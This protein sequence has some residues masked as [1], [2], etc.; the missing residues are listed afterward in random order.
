MGV[1]WTA[2]RTRT[3]DIGII[4][5]DIHDAS[6]RSAVLPESTSADR[7]STSTSTATAS[8]STAI[9]NDDALVFSTI[10]TDRRGASVEE[11]EIASDTTA[12][13]I[14][15]ALH[16]WPRFR[17]RSHLPGLFVRPAHR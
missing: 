4:E 15:H 9:S 7:S 8:I 11:G 10:C 1:Q 14:H 3:A 13:F 17:R 6:L 5:P 16:R 2:T 12:G